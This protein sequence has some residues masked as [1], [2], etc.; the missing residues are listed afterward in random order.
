[1]SSVFMDQ[2]P[3]AIVSFIRQ[4]FRHQCIHTY[5][6][7]ASNHKFK[8][9]KYKPHKNKDHAVKCLQQQQMIRNLILRTYIHLCYT[10]PS[11]L[12]L[13]KSTMPTTK[14]VQQGDPVGLLFFCLTDPP[15]GIRI[16]DF[17][18]CGLKSY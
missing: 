1:M 6:T 16:S 4:K 17:R 7:M 3:S 11:M 9:V 2:Q 10:S 14:G 18:H 12:S 8:K 5:S 15:P 13:H